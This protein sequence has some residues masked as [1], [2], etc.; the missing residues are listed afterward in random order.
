MLW[1]LA[2]HQPG[3]EF[4]PESFDSAD[5]QQAIAGMMCEML[6]SLKG[7]NIPDI[8]METL[9][10]IHNVQMQD[11]LGNALHWHMNDLRLPV[12]DKLRSMVHGMMPYCEQFDGII[13]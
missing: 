1:E 7:I 10:D 11:R 3:L 12:N 4:K 13:Y 9:S 5:M 2:P 6:I 8:D